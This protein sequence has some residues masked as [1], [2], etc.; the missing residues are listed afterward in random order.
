MA[1]IPA[2][3]LSTCSS[4]SMVRSCDVPAGMSTITN[5]VPVSSLGTMAVGVMAMS[6]TSTSVLAI[7]LRKAVTL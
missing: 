5:T 6:H 1:W 4:T 3:R 2:I 7:T